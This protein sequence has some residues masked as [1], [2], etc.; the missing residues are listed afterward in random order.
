MIPNRNIY[1]L[2]SITAV[3]LLRFKYWGI[4]IDIKKIVKKNYFD[5]T[6][7][8]KCFIESCCRLLSKS[9]NCKSDSHFYQCN[10]FLCQVMIG[11]CARHIYQVCL[12]RNSQALD[13]RLWRNCTVMC[14]HHKEADSAK[15]DLVTV[16]AKSLWID[17]SLWL[18]G[19]SVKSVHFCLLFPNGIVITRIL[20]E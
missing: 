20:T 2:G 19:L 5:L 14:I 6:F 13:A 12:P 15:C 3:L 4:N 1:N 10:V 7:F 16:K 8:S 17:S 18:H 9:F 11:W